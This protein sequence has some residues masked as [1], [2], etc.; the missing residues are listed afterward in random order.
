M[1]VVYI[2]LY[3]VDDAGN[4][5]PMECI[6][7]VPRR[8]GLRERMLRDRVREDRQQPQPTDAW[9]HGRY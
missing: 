9:D 8:Q 5:R 3:V 4:E 6:D 1:I 7:E 2:G